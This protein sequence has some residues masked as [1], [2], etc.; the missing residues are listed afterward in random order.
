MAD[1]TDLVEQMGHG[2][3][4]DGSPSS[5]PPGP[6]AIPAAW[7]CE[8]GRV[9]VQD[10][11][12]GAARLGLGADDLVGRGARWL[13]LCAPGQ[14]T[15]L[16]GSPS[17]R[18][19]APRRRLQEHRTELVT[20]PSRRCARP[21]A[22]STLTADGTTTRG[23]SGEF[24]RV[25]PM[26]CSGL[27][28]LRRRPEARWRRTPADVGQLGGVQRDLLR[29]ALDAAAPGGVVAYVTCSP[30]LAETRLIVSDVLKQREDV[31]Q[32]DARDAV[33]AGILPAVRDEVDRRPPSAVAPRP[34]TDAM[35]PAAR[36]PPHRRRDPEV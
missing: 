31:T 12:P 36:L 2:A 5:P 23:P 27:G 14:T 34:R 9:A 13:D 15:L 29:S 16:G 7:T 10:R 3:S 21:A 4:R 33:R 20:A 26:P 6:P 17:T 19:G 11:L 25:P 18:R 28:A 22:R 30:H 24:S 35:Y 8:G 1:T 32:L